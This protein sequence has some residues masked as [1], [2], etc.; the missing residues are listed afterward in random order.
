MTKREEL[1]AAIRHEEGAVPNWTMGFFVDH[2]V[3]LLGEEN[4]VTDFFPEDDY[5]MGRADDD[6]RLRN[7]RYVKAVDNCAIGIGKGATIS[8]GHGGP[9]E[10][11]EKII[12]R[13]KDYQISMYETGVKKMKKWNPNFYYNYDHPLENLDGV[14]SFQSPDASNPARYQGL[15]GD[16]AYYRERG[17]L[18]YANLNG[19]FS[20]IHYFLYPYE[21]LFVDMLLEKEKLSVLIKKL[22]HFNLTAAENLLRCGAEMI[23]TCDDMGDA[24]S[25]LF[26]CELYEEL[27]AP[28][29][30]ELAALCH[31]YGATLHL[32]C[33][34]N[35]M[36]MLPAIISTGI[37]I[38]NPFDPYEIGDISEIKERFGKKITICGGLDKFFFEFDREKMRA[39]L[40]R[41]IDIGRK[42]GGFILMDSGGVPENVTKETFSYYQQL[43]RELRAAR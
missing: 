20:G 4:V 30:A 36:K 22:A 8:F 3:E 19:I 17:Y 34:G 1:L 15:D 31:S 43:S 16:V 23:V 32:H 18:P 38:I 11:M 14:E 2:A 25:L 37:D 35:I 40:T 33:H 28:Y 9:G 24:R 7:V 6:N 26:S 21:K 13:G 41:V 39:F 10:M 42:G 12:E 29:H 27:F 5:K